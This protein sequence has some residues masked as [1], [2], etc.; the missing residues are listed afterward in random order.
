LKIESIGKAIGH[1][2][3][4]ISVLSGLALVILGKSMW[5]TGWSEGGG[6]PP[7]F[8]LMGVFAYF[9]GVILAGN[10]GLF[11]SPEQDTASS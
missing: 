6:V 11:G 5:D 2:T 8:I 1:T 4:A 3:A 7:V 10:A 9:S